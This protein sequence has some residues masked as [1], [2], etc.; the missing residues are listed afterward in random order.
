MRGRGNAAGRTE[1]SLMIEYADYVHVRGFS[2]SRNQDADHALHGIYFREATN[3]FIDSPFIQ[4]VARS[5]I[6]FTDEGNVETIENIFIAS[7]Q[8]EV[9]GAA[10]ITLDFGRANSRRRNIVVKDAGFR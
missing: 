6:H 5:A 8:I 2:T 3:V 1:H 9:R 4:G 7:P 10:A